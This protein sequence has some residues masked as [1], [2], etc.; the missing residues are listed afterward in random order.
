M[1]LTKSL[2]NIKRNAFAFLRTP[3]FFPAPRLAWQGGHWPRHCASSKVTKPPTTLAVNSTDSVLTLHA[4]THPFFFSCLRVIC[5]GFSSNSIAYFL[6]P[7]NFAFRWK[8][9]LCCQSH[10][11]SCGPGERTCCILI[12]SGK[13]SEGWGFYQL[14][15]FV[16]SLISSFHLIPFIHWEENSSLQNAPAPIFPTALPL[17][18]LFS[19]IWFG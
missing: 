5:T 14:L 2:G 19:L 17:S 8:A 16:C 6:C 12:G 1:F 11:H 18:R 7:P 10:F 13:S 15:R 4:Q 3:A 9:W